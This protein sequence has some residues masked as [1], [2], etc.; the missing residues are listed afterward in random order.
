MKK[1]LYAGLMLLMAP[2]AQA[3]SAWP[4]TQSQSLQYD[5]PLNRTQ[6]LGAHNAWNDSSATWANQRWT[7][8]TLLDN[9]VRN[10]D[11]DVHLDGG[12]VI[13]CHSA[14]NSIYSAEDSYDGELRKL[15]AWL[16][17][18]PKEVVFIDL[19]DRVGNQALVEGP[20]RQI[21]GDLLYRPSDK[22]ASRWETPRE[23]LAKGRRVLV[24]S[25][26][27][28]Y[29]GSLIWD[30][31]LFA[32][33]AAG[34]WNSR[35]VMYF[36]T[37]ACR[38]DGNP[39]ALGS[40]YAISDS[41]LGKDL[42]PDGWVDETGTI[43]ASNIGRLF[44]CGV[45]NVDA[46]RWDDGMTAAA[47]WHWAPGEPNNV[48]GEHCAERRGDGRWNDA[49]C[50]TVRRFACQH[51]GNAD[52]WRVTAGSGAWEQ[53]RAQCASEYPGY[54]FAVP[55]NS[56]QNQRLL[57]ASSG[58]SLWLNYSD[59]A[60]EGNWEAYF[61]AVIQWSSGAS[62]AASQLVHSSLYI[63]G[64]AAVRVTVTGG[65][66]GVGDSIQVFN[67]SR[68]LQQTF[69]GSSINSS[70]TVSDSGIIV[71]FASDAAYSGSGVTVQ[72]ESTT[73]TETPVWRSLV[74]G[75]GKC[76]DLENRS[77]S[78]GAVVHHWSCHGADSQKW[79]QDAQGRIHSKA[80]PNR[81]IDVSG[82]SS[83]NGTKIQLWD[84]HG[85]A[86]QVWLR[87]AANS[88]R[89]AHAPSKAMDIKDAWW[90]AYDGQ[91]THLWD[92]Q[93]SWGQSWSWR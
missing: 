43:D 88:L 84:C 59:A 12:T 92:G 14:C 20:L 27:H 24:K 38:L 72:I 42:L 76:L 5:T 3:D 89:P 19:E 79:W 68:Q 44:A 58:L 67:S 81:C 54:R 26:N 90:G 50:G 25:A 56:Y 37:A 69:T 63:P 57:A 80:S 61:P 91:D 45:N 75:K 36:D 21:F 51:L 73:L 66:D 85:G 31:R 32:T 82:A 62:Y 40:I 35:P 17:T 11:L 34:G 64:A 6:V 65:L 74:N 87:G 13:L 33:G 93:S 41:K 39:L 22:P 28:W 52:D 78:N 10:I 16:D 30:G 71:R 47:V 83:G 15:R 4:L 53:G 9:G 8:E 86:N 77:T 29:D 46:D 70:F 48:G 2:L 60:R 7:L 1:A 23:M 18:H 49:A 55:S